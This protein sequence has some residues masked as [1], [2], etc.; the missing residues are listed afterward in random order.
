M[1]PDQLTELRRKNRRHSSRDVRPEEIDEL[2]ATVEQQAE[3]IREL[4]AERDA[5]LAGVQ[6]VRQL[7]SDNSVRMVME[8]AIAAKERGNG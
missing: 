3:R 7:S 2:I 8:A 4:E 1:T 5:L 6:A